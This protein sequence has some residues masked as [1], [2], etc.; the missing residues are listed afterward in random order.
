MA[1][2]GHRIEE[3]TEFGMEVMRRSGEKAISYY[4]KGKPHVKF[5]EELITEAEVDLTE[6]FKTRLH[7]DFP[8]HQIF[9]NDPEDD[10]DYTHEGKRYLWIYDPLD[11]VANFQAGIPIWGISLALFDNFWPVFGMFY[12]PSTGDLFNARAGHDA[13]RGNEKINVS[14]QENINDESLLLTYSRFHRHYNSGFSGKI[15][16]MGCTAAHICY[17]AMGR[18]EAAVIANESYEDLAAAWIIVEAA[19]GKFYKMDGSEFVIGEYLE[20]QKSNEHLLVA[21]PDTCSQVLAF[22]NKTSA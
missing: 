18:A 8:E 20:G 16:N 1:L 5:D 10:K 3:L 7:A 4:G 19:G 17:V 9:Q 2:D 13:F 11:G 22:L 6:F 21:P 14:P 15:R 12:M